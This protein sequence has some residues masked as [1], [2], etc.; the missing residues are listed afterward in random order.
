[1][2]PTDAFSTRDKNN[3]KD[4]EEPKRV[5]FVAGRIMSRRIMAK[6]H[7]LNFKI[8]KDV[9]RYMCHVMIFSTEAQPEM[10]NIVFQKIT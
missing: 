3:F 10:Y 1:M 6:L 5:V 4:D 7:L 2:Y 9:Y 8:Q